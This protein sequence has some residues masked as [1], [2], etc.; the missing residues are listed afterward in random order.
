MLVLSREKDQ[1]IFIGNDIKIVVVDIGRGQ[2]KIGIEAPADV[3]IL[4]DNATHTE[5]SPHRNSR[6]LQR[7]IKRGKT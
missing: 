7:F 5:E 3:P 4:R 6:K 2:V 1:A